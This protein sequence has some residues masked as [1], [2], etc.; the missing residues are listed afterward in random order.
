MGAPIRIRARSERGATEVLLLM[1]H[2]METGLRR[3]E[4]GALIPTRYITAVH[5]SVEGRAVLD[6][7]MSQAVAK[8]PL[9][10]FRF[11]GGRPGERIAVRW[12]DS[13]GEHR[14]D[15]ALIS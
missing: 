12:T 4:A 9:L 14:Q 15:D 6:A 3:D 13:A 1:P 2:P 11:R 10:S 7:R 8:D 5:V